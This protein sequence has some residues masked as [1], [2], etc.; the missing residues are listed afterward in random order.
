L[1]CLLTPTFQD[2][3]QLWIVKISMHTFSVNYILTLSFAT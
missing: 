2:L 3:L 1:P